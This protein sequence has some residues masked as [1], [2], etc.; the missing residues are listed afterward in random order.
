MLNG[1]I[2]A[3]PAK[4]TNYT[5]LIEWQHGDDIPIEW[6]VVSFTSSQTNKELIKTYINSRGTQPQQQQNNAPAVP[7]RV[8][9]QVPV[10]SPLT[11]NTGARPTAPHGRGNMVGGNQSNSEDTLRAQGRAILRTMPPDDSPMVAG[12]NTQTNEAPTN[13]IVT[14]R[15]LAANE[16]DILSDLSDDEEASVHSDVDDRLGNPLDEASVSSD[17]DDSV[18][19]KD[20]A[21]E[22]EQRANEQQANDNGSA[23]DDNNQKTLLEVL[24]SLEFKYQEREST[25][26][27][28]WVGTEQ[29]QKS[30]YLGG[31]GLRPGIWQTFS[32][33]FECFQRCGGMTNQMV[34]NL[35]S[36]TN[37][38]YHSHLKLRHASRNGYYHSQRWKDVT[39]Q[40]MYRFLG[41]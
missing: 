18:V 2:V 12:H 40:E 24:R 15:S 30:M 11:E 28:N 13:R 3:C 22:N 33:P 14:R 31:E 6:S 36:S 23:E 19:V 4:R 16:G 27:Y 39:I 5:F 10:N 8:G 21:A 35:T 29:R 32:T 26:G 41:I 1:Q 7:T 38:Y 17:D 34:S 9:N 37:A 25:V 20:L